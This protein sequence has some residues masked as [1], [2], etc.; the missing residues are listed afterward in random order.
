MVLLISFLFL[1]DGKGNI[2]AVF[3]ECARVLRHLTEGES[4]IGGKGSKQFIFLKT[5]RNRI[6]KYFLE[7][8]NQGCTLGGPN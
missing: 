6:R 4:F 2:F 5:M 1:A 3:V 8:I 7:L